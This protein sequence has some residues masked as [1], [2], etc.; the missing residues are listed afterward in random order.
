M[1]NYKKAQRRR[2]NQE[3]K[4]E[5]TQ[6]DWVL[7]SEDWRDVVIMYVPDLN[8]IPIEEN[9]VDISQEEIKD[10][11]LKFGKC[12]KPQKKKM[13]KEADCISEVFILEFCNK[14]F[15]EQYQILV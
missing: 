10:A 2:R 11:F 14:I 5:N 8:N 3:T 12:R 6:T 13:K 9:Y 1:K 15:I 4:Q 7:C